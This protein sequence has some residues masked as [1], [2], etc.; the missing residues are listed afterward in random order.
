MDDGTF[1]RLGDTFSGGTNFSI[2]SFQPTFTRIMGS[3]TLRAGYDFRVYKQDTT[4]SVHSA[5]QYD[6]AAAAC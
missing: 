1:C 2:Y 4:P 5:G 3:H 6:F